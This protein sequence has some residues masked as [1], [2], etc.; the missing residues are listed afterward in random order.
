MTFSL[1]SIGFSV[2]SLSYMSYSQDHAVCPPST[3]MHTSHWFRVSVALR[4]SLGHAL[5]EGVAA[6][7]REKSQMATGKAEDG[8]RNAIGLLKFCHRW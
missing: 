4:F 5:A 6:A 8:T 1:K 7:R 2:S 3:I